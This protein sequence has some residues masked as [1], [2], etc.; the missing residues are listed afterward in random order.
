MQYSIVNLV[1]YRKGESII[2]DVIKLI[3][4]KIDSLGYNE[5]FERL[6]SVLVHIERAEK[7]FDIGAKELDEQYFNDVIYRTNQAYE[8]ILKEAYK[9]LTGNNP[10][11]L[12]TS[13]IEEHF[14]N[15]AIF[16]ERVKK[17]FSNYRTEWRNSSTHQYNLFFSEDEA[18][19]ALNSVASFCFVLLN[20]ISE[21]LSYNEEVEL[22]SNIPINNSNQEN[23]SL[24]NLISD[25]ILKFSQQ[26]NTIPSKNGRF[27]NEYEIAGRLNAY[28]DAIEEGIE[29][30]RE[31]LIKKDNLRY[32]L[33][34]IILK[35]E[36]KLLVE[37]KRVNK[38]NKNDKALMEQLIKYL[39]VSEID[40]GILYLFDE[41]KENVK[42]EELIKRGNKQYK[43]IKISPKI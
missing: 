10:N 2:V 11:R 16:K 18:F 39:E 29:V 41:N 30:K 7:Y 5:N 38:T 1:N 9:I 19:L 31:Q 25:Q 34:F 27:F 37:L 24:D 35:E 23:L 20:Q 13:Q 43:L 17:L 8:G 40:T 32:Y 4:E 33:D 15:N 14:V 22:L 28:L 3:K 36:K 6:N 42:S 26:V 21:K 12:K